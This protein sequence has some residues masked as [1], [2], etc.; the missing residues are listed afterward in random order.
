[1]MY[2]GIL[3]ALAAVGGGAFVAMNKKKGDS[4][5]EAVREHFAWHHAHCSRLLSS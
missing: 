2:V 5:E 4:E 3:V 1:M